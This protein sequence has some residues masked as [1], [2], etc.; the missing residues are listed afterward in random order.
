MPARFHSIYNHGFIR[1]SVCIPILRVADPK[2]NAARTLDLAHQ[3]SER[4]AAL[5][6]FPELGISAYSN[7]DLFHQNALLDAVKDALAG[8]VQ[9]SRTLSPVLIVGA[10]LRFHERLFNCA[11]MIY[12]G[13]VL[14]IV[15]KTYL[16]N[17]REFYEKRQFTPAS[18][19]V[20]GEVSFLGRAVPFGN[21]LV[22]HAVNLEGFGLHVELCE[23]V[24]AP[25][26]PSTYG[27]LAGATVIANL[28]ASNITIGKAEY[29][30]LLCASQSA[31]TLSAYLYSAAGPGES[32]TDLA[33]DGHA[34][35]YENGELLAESERFAD[36]EQVIG[37]DVD[38]ERLVQ[39]RMRT[40][41]FNDSVRDCEPKVKAIRRI[42]FAFQVPK[43]R[44]PLVREIERFPYV[45]GDPTARDDRCYEVY[46]IQVHGLMKRLQAAGIER[47]VIGIS[48][49][50][51]STQALI[52][53][54]KTMDRLGLPR[55]NILA[56]TM[57]GF[58][59][60]RITHR[61]AT[62]LMEA[63][64]ATARDLDIRPS[65]MQMFKDIGHPY[66]TG[67]KVYD[68]TFENVQ[69]GERTSHLFRLANLHRAIVLGTGDL[70][71]L[72]LGW[73][74]YGVGDQMSHYNVNASVPKTLIQFLI[75]WV[76]KTD[77]F[78]PEIN[79]VLESILDTEISP[80]LIPNEAGRNDRPG[81]STEAQIGPYALHDFSLYYVTRFGFRPSKVAFLCRQAWGD[82]KRG[83]WLDLIPEEKRTE[84]DLAAIKRWL[85][86]FLY[87]FFK[88]SQFKRSALPN[89]PKVG[90][91]GSLSPRGDWRAPSDS[92]ATVWLEELRKNVPDR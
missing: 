21:D 79:A 53:A 81:Q 82:R 86:V 59:T 29:R 36:K 80:E 56:Y 43:G 32:T 5:V 9:D 31:K 13:D 23:D 10:P 12:R 73:T 83:V 33:W 17:Y 41:S 37:V 38:L 61:N 74:T 75:R 91:G 4:N 20:S 47:V 8:L 77:Q 92:E 65:C 7:E 85:E 30:K 44:V 60:S 68:V 71:E 40:T 6:L 2:Y 18:G 87:R 64:E 15:P 48:G 63:L 45:P 62:R 69:A 50:L 49:G 3:A 76:I 34:L 89:G 24:W 88:I 11:V 90:S 57:P 54:A 70:S 19:A 84:Y 46:N 1:A 28:S 39:E 67:K 22:F 58:A 25:I 35:I 26:P 51:D 66:A 52:V 55:K 27:A 72:A 14:G 42:P 16:P 78:T